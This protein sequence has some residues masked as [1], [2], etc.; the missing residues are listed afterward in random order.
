MLTIGHSNR[1]L[2]DFLALLQEAGVERLI[3][4]RSQPAS[5]RFPWF[6]RG[7]LE[8][9][10]SEAGIAYA[11]EGPDLGGRREERAEDGERHPALAEAGFRAYARHMEGAAFRTAVDRLLTSPG[12]STAVMCA[13]RD[14]AHCHR[15][16]IAD[17]LEAV[18]ERPV[19][20]IMGPGHRERHAVHPGARPIGGI[21]RYDRSQTE[22]LL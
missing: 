5:R 18:R 2:E 1:A 9:A 4:V 13:E 14:P 17:Y 3:D 8:A 21:L 19:S 15:S 20:H 22:R 6:S 16:L 10:L 11:W 12:A 7:R